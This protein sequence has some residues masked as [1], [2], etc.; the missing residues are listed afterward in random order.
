M[1]RGQRDKQSGWDVEMVRFLSFWDVL[2]LFLKHK[3]CFFKCWLH[4]VS[5]VV[6]IYFY[7]WDG[8][9][10]PEKWSFPSVSGLMFF[11]GAPVSTIQFNLGCVNIHET[12]SYFL[13]LNVVILIAA[14][15]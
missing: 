4:V 10:V 5:S 9:A 12:S 15:G 14:M 11:F 13:F 1:Q 7:F 8:L 6:E 2:P 3:E